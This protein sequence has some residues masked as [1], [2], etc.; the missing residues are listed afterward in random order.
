MTHPAK[1]A[2]FGTGSWGTAFA[3]ILADAGCEVT[4]WGRRPE[5][6]EAV[7]TTHTNPD[8]L[9]GIALPETIR[10]T[11]D[12]AEALRGAEFA[13]LVVPSQT[14][15]ANLA[16]WAPHLEPET[17]L[18]SLMK[19]VELGTAELMSEVIADVTGVSADRIAVVSGPNLAKEI[20]ERRPAAAVVA[21]AD[22]S[23]A[24]RL[25]AACH[26]AYFRPYTNT[27]VVGCELGGAVKNVIGLAVGIADGMG[28]GDNTKGSL[29]TRGL[30]ETTRLGVAM[31]ADPLTFS[32]LAGLGD[33]VATCSSPL[34]RN[35]TFGT[36]L[37][38]GMTLQETI[39]VTK[40]T[41]EGVKSCESV[42]A[43]ARRHGVDMPI[44]ETVV[45]IVHEGKSPVVAVKELMS[46]SAKAER[47]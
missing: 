43:L 22:E 24:Q 19:G 37:G 4:L 27:D 21:C 8:Y 16:D 38:R 28:L 36:N 26:T 29:I 9:P 44:T 13:F 39:A 2:V 45:S 17:V 25:Q 7:N 30:A 35:H 10:A 31:G 1:V 40:Q 47:R 15:R 12:A 41:A 5:L 6:A 14:L 23:V 3:V 32:G 18:V 11:T 34:S 20:A 46:R 42:L 33:L